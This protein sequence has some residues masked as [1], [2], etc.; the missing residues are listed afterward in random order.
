[1]VSLLSKQWLDR[2][3]KDYHLG[4]ISELLGEELTVETANGTKIPYLGY[5]LL[6]FQIKNSSVLQVPFLVTN[7]NIVQ[8]IVGYNV[9]AAVLNQENQAVY[10]TLPSETFP[11]LKQT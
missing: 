6:D 10:F 7:E 9:I 5:V 3:V 2:Q 4:S 1:M 8:P 11:D